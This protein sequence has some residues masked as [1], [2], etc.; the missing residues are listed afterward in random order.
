ML[1]LTNCFYVIWNLRQPDLGLHFKSML[2]TFFKSTL[3]TSAV[4]IQWRISLRRSLLSHTTRPPPRLYPG[5]LHG[6]RDPC[7]LAPVPPPRLRQ[8]YPQCRSP[9][10]GIPVSLIV[11]SG[12]REPTAGLTKISTVSLLFIKHLL[13][14][15]WLLFYH[16]AELS[17]INMECISL[18]MECCKQYL[19]ARLFRL[20][21]Y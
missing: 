19:H 2:H 6:T 14:P 7:P 21:A 4:F 9:Q 3:S 1:P 11:L 20:Y 13:F 8:S 5:S 12:E 16:V 17:R 18:G 15:P 10:L